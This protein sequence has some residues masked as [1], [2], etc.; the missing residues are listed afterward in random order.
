LIGF[1]FDACPALIKKHASKALR[2]T[3]RTQKNNSKISA[4]YPTQTPLSFF[5]PT[6]V[7]FPLDQIAT[8]VKMEHNSC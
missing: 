6:N 2:A 1:R 5:Q 4:G 3:A 8:N 7:Q